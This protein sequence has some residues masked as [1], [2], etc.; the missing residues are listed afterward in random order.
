MAA[1]NQLK[2]PIKEKWQGGDKYK[3]DHNP[4][5]ESVLASLENFAI[6]CGWESLAAMK[7]SVLR[8]RGLG[9]KP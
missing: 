3:N 4:P 7:R 6:S 2:D 1:R 5:W 8:S 9:W